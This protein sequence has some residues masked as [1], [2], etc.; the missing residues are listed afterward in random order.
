MIRNLLVYLSNEIE[1]EQLSSDLQKLYN[2][3]VDWQMMFNTDK[4]KS[5]HFVN[6]NVKSVYLLGDEQVKDLG[7]VIHQSLK[8]PSHCVAAAKSANKTLGMVDTRIMLKLCQLLVRPKLEYCVQAWRPY[9]KKDIE[10]AF[11]YVKC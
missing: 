3:S 9:L 11:I 1:I 8:S 4:C 7:V 10:T 2:W 5:L 6:K